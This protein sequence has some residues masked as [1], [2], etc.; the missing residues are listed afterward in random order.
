MVFR[1]EGWPLCLHDK[2]VIQLAPVNPLLLR[3]G[4]FYLQAEPFGDQ[5]ARIVL[6]SLLEEGCR[7]VEETP[8]PETSYPCI[9]TEDWLQD[10]NEGRRGTPL[11]RCLLCT[12]QGVIKLPWAEIAIPEFLDKPKIMSMYVE[13]SPEPKQIS[14]PSRFNSSTLPLE[15]VTLPFNDRMSASLRP[16]D[17]SAKVDHEKR[18]PRSFTKPLMKPV[19]WV[20]PNTWDSRSYPEIEGDYVDLVDI[21]KGKEFVDKHESFPNPSNSVLFKP[22]RPPPPVPNGKSVFCGRT[23]QHAEQPCTPCSQRKLGHEPTEQDLKCRYRDSYLAALRNPVAFEKGSVD[24]LA[25][26]EEVGICEELELKSKG[27]FEAQREPT[28]SHELCQSRHCGEPTPEIFASRLKAL[29]TSSGCDDVMRDSPV[30][31]KSTPGLSY[32]HKVQTKRI[33]HQFGQ[34]VCGN[35]VP[36][37]FPETCVDTDTKPQQKV[38]AVKPSGKHKGKHRSPSTVSETPKGSPLFYKLSNRSHSDICP[39][40]IS[41]IMQSKK[42]ELLDQVTPKLERRKPPKKGKQSQQ[43]H[44][45]GMHY[46]L[47]K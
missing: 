11:S 46:D 16:V 20:S 4:D 28:T 36:E 23:V 39:E 41:S 47:Y 38:D 45:H 44:T 26:L 1:C 17:C 12:D 6:K 27:A 19:G 37:V 15:T 13:A 9:F 34:N 32:S 18:T 29:P 22:V 42:D 3:P 31:L 8:I 14:A 10:V 30:I 43:T 35:P 7:E 33:S 40:T 25:A 5:A 2:T 21:A 24:L